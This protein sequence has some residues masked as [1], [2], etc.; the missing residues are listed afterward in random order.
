MIDFDMLKK[1]NQQKAAAKRRG[2]VWRLTFDQ[3]VQWWGDDIIKRGK[4]A[5]CLQ[6]CRFADSGP[7]ALGNIYKGYP[8]DN[9]KT[10]GN[11]RR[12]KA[13]AKAKAAHQA[14]LDA[15]MFAPSKE[16]QDYLS[17]DDLEF[18][19]YVGVVR[20]QR[21]NPAFAADKRR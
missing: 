4:A 13:A 19:Q 10:A 5:E 21:I 15:L 6:M 14:Q 20:G 18:L 1:F 7:Y 2:I 11:V 17:D 16:A 9:M 3:W 12:E 8:R